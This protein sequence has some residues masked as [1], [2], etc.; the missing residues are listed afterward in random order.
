MGSNARDA[1]FGSS[2]RGNTLGKRPS[3]VGSGETPSAGLK[4]LVGRVEE[5]GL[6]KGAHSVEKV[7]GFPAAKAGKRSRKV[8]I[9]KSSDSERHYGLGN[10]RSEQLSPI[11]GMRNAGGER[12]FIV[13]KSLSRKARRDALLKDAS[14]VAEAQKL[15]E[16]DVLNGVWDVDLSDA[17]LAQA[18]LES[19][20]N[21]SDAVP[22][23]MTLSDYV[24]VALAGRDSVEVK[25]KTRE[26]P[27][28]KFKI[29]GPRVLSFKTLL[30]RK[31]LAEPLLPKGSQDSRPPAFNPVWSKEFKHGPISYIPPPPPPTDFTKP[32]PSISSVPVVVASSHGL[33]S[34]VSSPSVGTAASKSSVV[35]ASYSIS[36]ATSTYSVSSVIPAIVG[37]ADSKGTLVAPVSAASSP[38]SVS[39]T[40]PALGNFVSPSLVG[41]VDSK[42]TGMVAASPLSGALSRLIHYSRASSAKPELKHGTINL[43]LGFLDYSCEVSPSPFTLG[44]FVVSDVP[45]DIGESVLDING[46]VLPGPNK[47]MKLFGFSYEVSSGGLVNFVRRVKVVDIIPENP[48]TVDLRTDYMLRTDLVHKATDVLLVTVKQRECFRVLGC[49]EWIHRDDLITYR[50]SHMALVNIVSKCRQMLDDSI[51]EAQ[52]EQA[53]NAYATANLDASDITLRDGTFAFGC[54]VLQWKKFEFAHSPFHRPQTGMKS[55]SMDI[56]LKRSGSPTFPT[57]AILFVL[58]MLSLVLYAIGALLRSVWGFM[59]TAGHNHAVILITLVILGAL[60][61]SGL[62][63]SRLRWRPASRLFSVTS[64]HVG[65]SRTSLHYLRRANYLLKNGLRELITQADAVRS[66]VASTESTSPAVMI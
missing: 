23:V 3:R 36:G 8:Y 2:S 7:C 31:A 19:Y 25:G 28:L 1:N 55:L 62:L 17:E 20:L 4:P 46:V 63:H 14:L 44:Y 53:V 49:Y 6:K 38:I 15:A 26:L 9:P 42:G 29:A 11:K 58:A 60:F 61:S 50:V 40:I 18:Y 43:D 65:L 47:Y 30:S 33:V 41:N 34:A 5:P 39:S 64:Y 12:K 32:P 51:A 66:F 48:D 37:N 45:A 52:I 22:T 35:A 13:Q 24:A 10:A 54:H 57:L 21:Y 56:V 59:F 16:R 27:G